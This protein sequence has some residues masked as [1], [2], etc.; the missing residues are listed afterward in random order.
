MILY[1]YITSVNNYDGCEAINTCTRLEFFHLKR[2]KLHFNQI[3]FK[4]K[5]YQV[6]NITYGFN[7][8]VL[9]IMLSD[10]LT[11]VYIPY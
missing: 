11:K 4:H 10:E 6:L 3:Y 5:K 2:G 9:L 8:F 1:T 7:H